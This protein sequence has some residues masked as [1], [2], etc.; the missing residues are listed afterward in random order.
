MLWSTFEHN[1]WNKKEKSWSDH[2]YIYLTTKKKKKKER[3]KGL[4]TAIVVVFYS[5]SN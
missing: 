1:G 2:S 5:A 3:Q 4:Y